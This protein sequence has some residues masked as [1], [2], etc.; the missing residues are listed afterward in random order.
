M[1][2]VLAG[3]PSQA[4][5]R[6]RMVMW[7]LAALAVLVVLYAVSDILA[8]MLVSALLAYLL[9]P[10][11]KMMEV[12]GWS[13]T[14][15]TALIFG[16]LVLSV[17]VGVVFLVP[18]LIEQ[19]V[20]LQSGFEAETVE[21]IVRRAE[22]RVAPYA[23][24]FGKTELDLMQ[25][26]RT[27]VLDSLGE[28]LDYVPGIL[29][30]LGNAV[31]VPVFVFFLLKDG[32]SIRKT[33][34]SL[35]PNTYFEFT[36]AV[37]RKMNVQ[38]GNYLRGQFVCAFIV[39]QLSV[40]A[41]WLLGVDYYVI[42]GVLAGL[43]NLIPYLGPLLGAALAGTVTVLTTGS[44]ALVPFI[45]GAFALIQSIDNIFIQPLIIA[46]NADLHPIE[47]M[48]ALLVGGQ[49]FG[50]LGLLLAVPALAVLK[51]FVYEVAVNLRRYRLA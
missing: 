24:W 10:L 47:I 21:Q 1:P 11:V 39:A 42:I 15:A 2:D 30:L 33:F 27:A 19:V 8:L 7:L 34:V 3:I 46:R 13:R 18:V 25:V 44:L 36:L 28:T 31:L 49:F 29:S 32:R 26:L 41:L 43:A 17:G 20:A 50:F 16:V 45:I 37:L 22:G 23:A 40:A 14:Q 9:A 38:V 4:R 12:H 6:M 5:R 51:V 35:V 48:L